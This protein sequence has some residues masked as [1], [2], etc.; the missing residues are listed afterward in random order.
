MEIIKKIGIRVGKWTGK[1]LFMFVFSLLIDVLLF[2][3]AS[4]S[5][6]FNNIP[7][8]IINL[9][10]IIYIAVI[11]TNKVYRLI[12]H[13]LKIGPILFFITFS[14]CSWIIYSIA[15]EI[16]MYLI[17]KTPELAVSDLSAY[18]LL[19]GVNNFIYLVLLFYVYV[20]VVL[21]IKKFTPAIRD[22]ILWIK[23]NSAEKRI[24]ALHHQ[25]H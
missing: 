11:H 12:N 20:V 8:L 3:G 7:V 10:F 14:F 16:Y 13:K 22:K 25:Y 9:C 21:L 18:Y 6:I 15:A 23:E 5:I 4:F 19:F 24:S 1:L 2:L 17:D